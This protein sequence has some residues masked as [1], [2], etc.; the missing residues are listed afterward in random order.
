MKF[1]SLVLCSMVVVVDMMDY[2]FLV[3]SRTGEFVIGRRGSW[4]IDQH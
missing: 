4:D 3:V 2:N 1:P